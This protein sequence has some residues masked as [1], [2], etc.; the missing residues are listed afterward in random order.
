[1]PQSSPYMTPRTFAGR[2]YVY[3]AFTGGLWSAQWLLF[4]AANGAVT[5]PTLFGL[6]MLALISLFWFFM[7][8]KPWFRI[9]KKPDQN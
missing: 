5:K 4:W 1:M 3:I 9:R 2:A 6:F 8:S 7:P